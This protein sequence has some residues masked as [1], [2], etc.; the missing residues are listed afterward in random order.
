ML[1]GSDVP[2]STKSAGTTPPYNVMSAS[3]IYNKQWE[4]PNVS[5][6]THT[7]GTIPNCGW[8][9]HHKE[10]ILISTRDHHRSPFSPPPLPHRTH[11]LT[12]FVTLCIVGVREGG[13]APFLAF[14]PDNGFKS[15]CQMKWV[16]SI[17]QPQSDV[18]RSHP[19]PHLTPLVNGIQHLYAWI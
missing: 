12:C 2:H 1:R 9:I 8:P 15:V 17:T 18:N 14:V 11:L 16:N 13:I 5:I 19:H 3:H 6:P 10:W 7:H 4:R